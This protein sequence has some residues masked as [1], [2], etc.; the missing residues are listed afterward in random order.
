MGAPTAKAILAQIERLKEIRKLGLSTEISRKPHQ[1][2]LL[3]LARKGG[4]TAVYQ[5]KE[6]EADRRR[7]HTA[8]LS[9][10]R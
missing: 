6:Y 5:L 1:N 10:A 4:Q 2:R 7:P 9:P 3:Q 8:Q